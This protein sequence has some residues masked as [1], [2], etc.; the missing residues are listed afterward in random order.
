MLHFVYCLILY[1][2]S[3]VILNLK[4]NELYLSKERPSNPRSN[5][6]NCTYSSLNYTYIFLLHGSIDD[7]VDD[8]EENED[9]E[10]EVEDDEEE[11]EDVVIVKTYVWL[12]LLNF[13][14]CSD[15]SFMSRGKKSVVKGTTKKPVASSPAK[16][17]VLNF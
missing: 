14:I 6:R 12:Y 17:Y 1:T 4:S 9:A 13:I 11:E 8:D 7:E 16:K 10:E 3:L 15:N 2:L 5:Q